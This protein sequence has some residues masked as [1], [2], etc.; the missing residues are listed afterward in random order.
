VQNCYLFFYHYYYYF[1]ACGAVHTFALLR[2]NKRARRV[3][4]ANLDRDRVSILR[5]ARKR[6][7]TVVRNVADGPARNGADTSGV[8]YYKYS[9][10]VGIPR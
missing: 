4:Y 2:V 6:G 10:V 5:N 8:V 3:L 1:T 7:D 9:T